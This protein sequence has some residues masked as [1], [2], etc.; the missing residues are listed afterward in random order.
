MSMN[1][2]DHGA[3]AQPGSSSLPSTFNREDARYA[4]YCR[5]ANG[6]ASRSADARCASTGPRSTHS[7]PPSSAV[8]MVRIDMSESSVRS[9]GVARIKIADCLSVLPRGGLIDIQ[10]DDRIDRIDRIGWQLHDDAEVML[11][12]LGAA[13][14]GH[15][16]RAANLRAERRGAHIPGPAVAG[17]DRRRN[18][19]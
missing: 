17:G 8:R 4:T 11:R 6:S 15:E 16:P 1:V 19:P 5:G 9:T 18:F 2:S 10:H 7:S 12:K 13:S 14:A 3:A